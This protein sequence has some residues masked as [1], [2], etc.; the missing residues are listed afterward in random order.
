MPRAGALDL[1][2]PTAS[3]LET[4]AKVLRAL[5]QIPIIVLP[6]NDDQT[7]GGCRR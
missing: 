2:C 7:V 1:S 5:P 3:A 4:F 6:G